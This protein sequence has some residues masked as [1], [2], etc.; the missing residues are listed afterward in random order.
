MLSPVIQKIIFSPKAFVERQI[1]PGTEGGRFF[2][3][4][5]SKVRP[6]D[7]VAEVPEA[8]RN[9]GSRRLTAGVPGEVVKV[10][11]GK[12]V[13]I[14]TSAVIIRGVFARGEDSEGEVRIAANYD[15]PIGLEAIDGSDSGQILVG[16]SVLSLEVFKKAEA[17]G[18]KGILCG[19][20]DFVALQ[21]TRL[22]T[23]LIDGFGSPP[24][25]R[26]VFDF[27]KSVEGRHVFLSPERRELLVARHFDGEE[28]CR[29]LL[30]NQSEEVSEAF[31]E[32]EKGFRVQVF[33]TPYFGQMGRVEKIAGETVVVLLENGDK[34]EV[35]GRNLG[36]IK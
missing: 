2:V 26:E 16:G 5:G 20:A 28:D 36:I 19:G 8:P 23:L 6:F 9:Q 29:E 32:L 30:D 10:L 24:L 1:P 34:I 25:N 4:E 31:I 14:K 22:P 3:K 17:V 33:T 21:R 18:V 7:F 12:A 35:P 15:E 13:L 27:L 11:P